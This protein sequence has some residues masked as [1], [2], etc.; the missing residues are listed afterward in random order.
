MSAIIPRYD[1]PEAWTGKGA[2]PVCRARGRLSVV[3]QSATPDQMWCAACDAA[4]EVESGGAHVRL[5]RLPA[6]GAA[7]PDQL[8]E[9]WVLPSELPALLAPA[10]PVPPAQ[11]TLTPF[12]NLPPK[13]RLNDSVREL[14]YGPADPAEPAA[15][16]TPPAEP[17][18]PSPAATLLASLRAEPPPAADTPA[19]ETLVAAP[20]P[21]ADAAPVIAEPVSAEPEPAAL[22]AE[23]LAELPAAPAPADEATFL[24][25]LVAQVAAPAAAA[26]ELDSLAAEAD[27][28]AD[29]PAAPAEAAPPLPDT[30]LPGEAAALLAQVLNDLPAAAPPA[31]E[32]VFLDALAAG[33]APDATATAPSAAPAE[34]GL[35]AAGDQTVAVPETVIIVPNPPDPAELAARA[36]QLYQLGNALPLIQAALER[37]GASAD[38]VALA[39]R[40]VR[41]QEHAR[42]ARHARTYRMV[43]GL[44]LVGLLLIL[45]VGAASALR[46]TTAAPV[47]PSATSGPTLTPGGPTPSPTLAYNPII[48]LINLIMPSDVKIVNGNSPTPGPTSAWFA[49]LFPNTPTPPPEQATAQA[50]TAQ[51]VV[52]TAAAVAATEHIEDGV[53]DW[54]RALVPEGLTVVGV[55]TPSVETTGPPASDCPFTAELAA[56]MFGGSSGNWSYDADNNGWFMTVFAQPVTVRVPLNMSAGYLVVGETMEFRNVHGPATITNVNFVAIS[57]EL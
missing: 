2:C 35:V 10:A 26:A 51:S 45:I 7:A 4:F 57:C 19:L 47:G 1:L 41:A 40:D 36:A 46:L 53:P 11:A 39:M 34:T 37:T 56:A 31:D 32:A 6:T 3:H 5:V 28:L 23:L 21:L 16:P 18:A 48:A 29:A 15:S 25:S 55:P 8:W 14:L 17:P 12:P 13:A 33:A 43:G 42:Q 44:A 54:I 22:L 49:R 52:A 30:T 38:Q 24:D 27:T 20:A 50:A 9:Q